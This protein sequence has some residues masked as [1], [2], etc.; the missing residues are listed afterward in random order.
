VSVNFVT[1]GCAA[2]AQREKICKPAQ[3]TQYRG[4]SLTRKGTPLGPYR[5]PK[6][7]VL[8]GS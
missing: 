8:G 6:P 5:R 4:T 7:R 1:A 2:V 3:P